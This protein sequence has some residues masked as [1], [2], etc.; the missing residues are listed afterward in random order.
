MSFFF[1]FWS[2]LLLPIAPIIV[3]GVIGP[4]KKQVRRSGLTARYPAHFSCSSASSRSAIK[5]KML[6]NNYL[7]GPGRLPRY[8]TLVHQSLRGHYECEETTAKT[9]TPAESQRG[10]MAFVCFRC[11]WR[12]FHLLFADI[13]HG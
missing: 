7:F 2:D 9:Q 4:E 11:D 5:C 3:L 6:L 10:R 12:S 8:I 1:F 13:A